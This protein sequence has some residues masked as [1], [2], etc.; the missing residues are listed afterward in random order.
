M[1]GPKPLALRRQRGA[2]VSQ[3]AKSKS[4]RLQADVVVDTDVFHLN[5]RFSYAIPIDLE[6]QIC[7]GSIVNIPFSSTNKIGVVVSVDNVTEGN[8]KWISS[9]ASNYVIP[10]NLM[11]LMSVLENEY[12]CHPFDLFRSV[13]PPLSKLRKDISLPVPY[14]KSKTPS[15]AHFVRL[16][17]GEDPIALILNRILRNADKRRIIIFPTLRQLREFCE[18]A[19]HLRI[20]VVELGAHV[21]PS[22]R[23]SRYEK[24]EQ[25][26]CIAGM[27][28]AIFAPQKDTDE[29]IIVDEFSHHF[30][31]Q[32]SPY[33]NLRDVALQRAL[34]DNSELFFVGI[35]PSLELYRKIS[36]GDVSVVR[37]RIIPSLTKRLQIFTFPD[38]YIRSIRSAIKGGSVLLS[39]AEKH[40]ANTFVCHTCRNVSRCSCG[41]KLF[42]PKR[43][44]FKCSLCSRE[45]QD[46]RCQECGS[47]KIVM[48]SA[49]VERISEEIRRS[50]PNTAVY[51][52]T[53][54][55]E[56]P[57]ISHKCLV[58]A[59]PGME[60]KLAGGYAAIIL[61]NG[62]EQLGRPSIHAEEDLF[63]QWFNTLIQLEKGGLIYSSLPAAHRISQALI[64]MNPMKYLSSELEDRK[65]YEL[66]PF[67]CLIALT[68]RSENLS[69]LRNRIAREFPKCKVNLSSDAR[70][71]TII[72]SQD[73]EANLTASLRA[74]QKVRSIKRLPLL[75]IAKNP[76]DI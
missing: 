12:I 38:D 13:L 69:G 8:L 66:P 73:D 75:K 43:N 59:T 19:N 42:L 52:S 29:I 45:S 5:E 46:W 17:A 9:L 33:W 14:E 76:L 30:Q 31:E 20:D 23:K 37:K 68:G 27:R 64:A 44:L 47:K 2:A 15:S 25:S 24:A 16:E 60:P 26:L 67:S 41:G 72:C 70:E 65:K 58:I 54:E 40:F 36:A 63:H 34:I 53:K 18:R 28:S 6:S 35:T 1:V 10:E 7:R 48:L 3:R 21:I 55:R 57:N 11:T 74:L 32:R 50:F 51:T 71:I 4:F 62:M 22:L 39:V 61:L 56:L 49:G